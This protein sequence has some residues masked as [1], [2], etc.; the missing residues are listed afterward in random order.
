MNVDQ[1]KPFNFSLPRRAAKIADSYLVLRT[2]E[3]INQVEKERLGVGCGC[4]T[5]KTQAVS[6]VNR[7]VNLV[8]IGEPRLL[9]QY[10]YHLVNG[11]IFRAGEINCDED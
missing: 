11:R 3:A 2:K 7:W 5:C 9:Q 6:N 10:Q 4:R 1:A 8:A